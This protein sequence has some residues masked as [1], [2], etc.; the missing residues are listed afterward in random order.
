MKIQHPLNEI[1]WQQMA[2]G[3]H[4][5]IYIYDYAHLKVYLKNDVDI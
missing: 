5:H 4:M 2:S 1:S 3:Q